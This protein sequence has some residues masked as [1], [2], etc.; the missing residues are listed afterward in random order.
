MVKPDLDTHQVKV[1]VLEPRE[2]AL[3]QYVT[4]VLNRQA[5]APSKTVAAVLALAAASAPLPACPESEISFTEP[6]PP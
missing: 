5:D 6:F 1:D 4:S 2:S 3:S